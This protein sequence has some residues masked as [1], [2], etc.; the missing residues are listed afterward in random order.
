MDD[1]TETF[2]SPTGWVNKHIHSYVETDGESGHLWQGKP[3]LLL[4]T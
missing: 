4:T 1:Q 2:D 3:T